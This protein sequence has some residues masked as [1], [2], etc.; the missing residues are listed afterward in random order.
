MKKQ[1]FPKEIIENSLDTHEFSHSNKSKIIYSIILIAV[2]TIIVLLPIIKVDIYTST[3]GIVKS[4]E[5]KIS[6]SIIN[7]GEVVSSNLKNHKKV[8]KGDTLLVI[9]NSILL[10]KKKLLLKQIGRTEMLI[11]DISYILENRKI[12]IS[13]IKSLEYRFGFGNYRK[14][15]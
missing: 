1:I 14:F 7:T 13:K 2:A 4:N 15:S 12:D 6:L 3:R 8:L 5:E 10:E 9:N 11:S